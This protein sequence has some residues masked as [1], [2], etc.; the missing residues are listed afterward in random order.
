MR[1]QRTRAGHHPTGPVGG[2][3]EGGGG[4]GRELPFR[5]SAPPKPLDRQDGYGGWGWGICMGDRLEGGGAGSEQPHDQPPPPRRTTRRMGTVRYGTT[6]VTP[7]T[8][9]PQLV[10]G[11]GKGERSFIPLPFASEFW[12]GYQTAPLHPKN[13]HNATGRTGVCCQ[14][15]F[16][17]YIYFYPAGGCARMTTP[18]TPAFSCKIIDQQLSDETCIIFWRKDPFY[19]NPHLENNCAASRNI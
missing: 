15:W 19:I 18:L 3:C 7:T 17:S 9:Q 10:W 13:S 12:W 16:L 8:P 6:E 2:G 4:A 1:R 14:N 11:G 5:T